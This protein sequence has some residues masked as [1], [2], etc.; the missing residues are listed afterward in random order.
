MISLDVFAFSDQ[1][2]RQH[3]CVTPPTGVPVTTIIPLRVSGPLPGAV[4]KSL[5]EIDD[6]ASWAGSLVD[7]GYSVTPR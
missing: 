6:L 5:G 1:S 3:V 7:R 2:G 4:L